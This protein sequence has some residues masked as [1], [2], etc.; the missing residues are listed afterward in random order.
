LS[1]HVPAQDP[2]TGR[3]IDG[4]YILGPRIGQGAIGRVYR[5]QQISLEREVAVKLLNPSFAHHPEA[6][7]R[8]QLEAQA[9]SRISH[10]GVV[11]VLDWGKDQSG[12]LYLVTEYLRGR[13]LFEL[14]QEY[15]PMPSARVARL[16]QQVALA[17]AH[18]HAL[19]IVH[20]DLKPENLRVI[21]DPWAP[22]SHRELVKIYDFGAAQ[23]TRS[24]RRVCTQVGVM[25]GTPYYMSPEQAAS[26]EAL[27]QSDL[28]SCGV[29]M[30]LLAAGTLPF[31]GPSPLDVAAM[32]LNKPAPR[33][34][35]YNAD[36][37]RRLEDVILDCLAKR[38]ED[39]PASAAALATLLEPIASGAP[40]ELPASFALP[41]RRVRLERP[42]RWAMAGAVA[43]FAAAGGFALAQSSRGIDGAAASAG[44]VCTE[45]VHVE[46]RAAE[47][48]ASPLTA[49]LD[50]RRP[51]AALRDAP[52]AAGIGAA[53]Q[54]TTR[55]AS[56]AAR[57][58]GVGGMER[59]PGAAANAAD[60]AA[61]L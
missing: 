2:L 48:R 40:T 11:T 44:V 54:V 56:S 13:D 57:F 3:L 1:L 33:P 38:P 35:E 61:Q 29:I 22:A 50:L 47:R 4:K 41:L 18:A 21:E 15:A 58:S 6:I 42:R 8:F 25:V 45:P 26:T 60:R 27:P 59:P 46:S 7:A 19:D 14:A 5:A 43:A 53:A 51:N 31:V 20:R 12:L 16:M 23:V 9:A 28:Y 24:L 49:A 10:P 34:S 52:N 30:F 17:L 39:R 37:D 32:H 55:A 36:I